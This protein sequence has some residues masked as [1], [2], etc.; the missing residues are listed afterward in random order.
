MAIEGISY[1]AGGNIS[2]C[3]FVAIESG[4]DY[5][6]IQCDASKVPVGVCGKGKETYNGTYHATDG[7]PVLVH[8][9]GQTALL[10]LGGVVSAGMFLKSD[11]DG[12]GVEASLTASSH[13]DIGA[14]A[15]MS[16]FSGEFVE[17]RVE[18]MSGR[19]GNS[20]T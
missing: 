4:T 1:T 18:L 15:L 14:R 19:Q 6:A 8:G 17:V 5:T 2:P 12:K 11:A 20:A 16:G 3:R 9:L 10:E 7:R 13:Q